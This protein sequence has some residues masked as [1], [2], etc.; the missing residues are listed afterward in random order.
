MTDDKKIIKDAAKDA[1]RWAYAE[2]FHGEGAGTRRRL[3][4]MELD[5]KFY[6]LPGSLDAFNQAYEALDKTK[7]V[8]KAVKEREHLDRAAKVGKNLRAIKRG[9]LRGVSTGLYVVIGV[10][11]I[12]HKTGYDKKIEAEAKKRWAKF[13]ADRKAKGTTFNI[14]NISG[15]SSDPR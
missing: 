9:D 12:A 1:E 8:K 11:V 3:L 10:A 15:G 14:T 4:Q 13:Q 5:T 2:A 6:Q 7:L